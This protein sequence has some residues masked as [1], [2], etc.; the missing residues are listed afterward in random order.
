MVLLTCTLMSNG[1]GVHAQAVT[2]LEELFALAET[3]SVHLQPYHTACAETV[4][5]IKI[6]RNSML[7]EIS[8]SLSSSFIGNG[9]TTARNLSDYQVAPIPHWGSGVSFTIEQPLYTGGA[10]SNSIKLADQKLTAARYAQE[11]GRDNLRIQLAGYYLD[12]MKSGNV[13]RVIKAN[14]EAAMQVLENIRQRHSKGLALRTDITRYELLISELSIQLLKIENTISILN[15]NL[16]RTAGLKEGTVITPDSSMV[17]EV[18]PTKTY[19]EWLEESYAQ[20][21]LLALNK[22]S[23]DISRT[24]EAIAKAERIPKV[25]LK[26][27]WTMDGPILTEIPPINRN[28]SYWYVGVGVSYN[29]SSLFKSG[30]TIRKSQLATKQAEEKRNIAAEELELA[31]NADYTRYLESAQELAVRKKAVDLALSNYSTVSARYWEGMA[32]LTDMLDAENAKLDA[33]VQLV[34]ARINVFYNYY[35]LKFITGQI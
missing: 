12:I 18:T 14:I 30:R 22:S 19:H 35:K 27:A 9:F 29:L 15:K 11:L 23:V 3:N 10:L 8:S 2:T 25:G 24:A 31:V 28:L 21:P 13:R 5:D 32:L 17:H 33:Q 6:A 26:A 1:W 16:S 4:E 7:P 20:S 34:N